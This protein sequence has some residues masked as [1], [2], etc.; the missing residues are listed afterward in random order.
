[1]TRSIDTI[2]GGEA[3]LRA[4]PY[5]TPP[6]PEPIGPGREDPDAPPPIEEPPGFIPVPPREQP[7]VPEHLAAPAVPA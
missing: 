5:P 1:M 6:L 2:P 3:A 4:G 7:P